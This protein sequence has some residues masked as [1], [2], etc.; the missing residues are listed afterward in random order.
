MTRSGCWSMG[1]SLTITPAF[2][3]RTIRPRVK[4]FAPSASPVY[5]NGSTQV[6]C[7]ASDRDGD[8]IAY[9]WSAS[10]GAIS[11][12]G[13][14]VSWTAPAATGTFMIACRVVDGHGAVD[15]AFLTIEVVDSPLSQPVIRDLRARPGV[16]DPG[17][18][19]TIACTASDP[20]GFPLSYAW[21]SAWGVVQPLDSAAIWTAPDSVGNMVVVCVVTNSQ[22]GTAVDSITIPVR[23]F[24]GPSTGPPVLDLRFDGDTGDASGFGNHGTATNV[25]FVADRFGNAGRAAGF[26]GATSKVSIP[27]SPSLN[28]DSAITVSL[29]ARSGLLFNREMFLVSHG[30]WQN[31]WKMSITPERRVRWTVKTDAGVKDVDSRT[32]MTAGEYLCLTGVYSGSDLLLYVNGEMERFVPMSGRILTPGIDLLVGQM[33]PGDANYNF[34]GVVDGVLI[35]PYALTYPQVVELYNSTVPVADEPPALPL[36]HGLLGNYPNPFNGATVCRYRIASR[37][38]VRL[39][40]YDLLGRQVTMLVDEEQEAGTYEVRFDGRN[41]ASGVYVLRLTVRPPEG[42]A[43]PIPESGSGA[44][45]ETRVMLLMK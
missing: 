41:L 43:G 21:T 3:R 39:A 22:G 5:I 6:C 31:R 34:Q 24:S 10:G 44:I 30:S 23:D 1:S 26:N 38:G 37:T 13:P 18:V 15:S 25:L 33:L 17:G 28:V 36:H 29:W 19:T 2:Y 4:G 11:G 14:T 20:G 7:T 45:A 27:N 9:V 12:N 40:V 16:V 35:Y 42:A 8:T 32:L